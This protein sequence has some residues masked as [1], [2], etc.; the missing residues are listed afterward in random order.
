[1]RRFGLIFGGLALA[2][3]VAGAGFAQAQG[4]FADV[5]AARQ[6]GMKQNGANMGAI[7]K[8]LDAGGDLTSLAS[9]AQG[10]ADFG[11]KIG[12]SFPTGSGPESGVKT[13]AMPEIWVSKADFEKAAANLVTQADTLMAALKANDKAAATAAFGATGGTCGACHRTFQAKL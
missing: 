1:M 8:G 12:A 2:A 9:N 11:R 10:I 3:V 7:K 6:A 13:R 5:I 4:A